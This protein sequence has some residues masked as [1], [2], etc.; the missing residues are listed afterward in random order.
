[1]K[2]IGEAAKFE[3]DDSHA[4]AHGFDRNFTPANEPKSAS[5]VHNV[6]SKNLAVARITASAIASFSTCAVAAVERANSWSRVTT[7][8][9]LIVPAHRYESQRAVDIKKAQLITRLEAKPFANVLRD[10]D[11]ILRRYC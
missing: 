7:L 6:A 11:L 4:T 3:V 9:W 10:D 1:M 5:C 8:A 2:L